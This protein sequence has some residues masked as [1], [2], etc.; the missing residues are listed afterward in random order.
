MFREKEYR[1]RRE[2]IW[3]LRLS[4]GILIIKEEFASMIW[5]VEDR[6]WFSS[7]C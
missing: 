1:V 7:V 3:D 2:R 5:L 6:G 4:F